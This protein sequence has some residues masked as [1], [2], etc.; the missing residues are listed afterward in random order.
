MRVSK[1]A[2]ARRR[3][4]LEDAEE[5]AVMACGGDAGTGRDKVLGAG[6]GD[7]RSGAG[8]GGRSGSCWHRFF[9][10]MG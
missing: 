10:D 5:A 1:K 8:R 7:G 9:K 6:G 3:G 4:Q 2:G